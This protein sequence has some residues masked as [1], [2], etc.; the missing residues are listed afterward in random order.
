MIDLTLLIALT[1]SLIAFVF[2]N[3][4]T[5][6]TEANSNKRS[7]SKSWYIGILISP[8]WMRQAGFQLTKLWF[9]MYLLKLSNVFIIIIIFTLSTYPLGGVL[10]YFGLLL[11]FFLP[12]LIFCLIRK[13]R[14]GAITN[15]LEFFLQVLLVYLKVGFTL[16]QAFG[17]AIS[18][19]L[20]KKNP[21]HNELNLFIQEVSAGKDK[22]LAFS[23]LYI[24]TGVQDIKKLASLILVGS[25]LGTPLLTS[26]KS[27]LQ[28][29]E[30]KKSITLTKKVNRKSLHTTFPI[31]LICF[32]MFLVLVFFPSALQVMNVLK[33]LVD[34]L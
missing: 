16:E 2:I 26:I 8:K 19:G 4:Q 3:K 1:A 28:S 18:H 14:Q 23:D 29:Y 24:R 34:S 20:N 13:Q 21:L 22:E 9:A 12:E 15:S 25:K 17:Y 30:L 11:S 5:L 6:D 27:L 31:L 10:F 7:T 32:P 33:L